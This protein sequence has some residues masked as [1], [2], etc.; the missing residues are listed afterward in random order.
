LSRARNAANTSL[1]DGYI[2]D[3]RDRIVPNLANVLIA[4]RTA[5]DLADAF[6]Y[7]EMERAPVLLTALPLA[8]NGESAGDDQ[9]PRPVRDA[10][11]SQLQEVLQHRDLPKVGKDTA[12]QAVDQRAQE[13]SF[14]P[15][16]DYLDGLKWDGKSRL[17]SWLA[18]HIG[19]APSDYVSGMGRMFLVGMVARIYEPGCKAD[20]M[21]VLEGPQG[22]GKSSA[23][24]VLAGQWFSD[25]LPD[26]RDKDGSQ[27]LRGKWLIEISELS[28]IGRADAEA[29]KAFI[30]RSEE[31]YRPSYGR[32]EVIEPRKCIFVGTTNKEAYLR[33]ETGERRFWPV[34]GGKID[35]DGLK[36]DRDQLFAE[37]VHFY[38]NGAQWWP[39][40][41]FEREHIKPQQQARYEAD[42]WEQAIL[43]YVKN[44]SRV[45]VTDVARKALRLEI[46][47]IGT[48]EQRRIAGVLIA[49][50]WQSGKDWK[51]RFYQRPD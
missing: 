15:V 44:L 7:D 5:P 41:D 47:R 42:A 13:C 14:H 43:A 51:G 8:P 32:K 10:D 36:R 50:G 34:K 33:D 25:S 23:C 12:H 45:R 22:A 48:A 6:A 21:L 17:N 31:R 26:I 11:V 3:E 49:N 9:Y 16:R 40:G 1:Q 46:A 30:T 19:A 20:Y 39:G 18:D 29:L 27:H 4:L 38:R 2:R 24:R 37:A 28:A 35:L